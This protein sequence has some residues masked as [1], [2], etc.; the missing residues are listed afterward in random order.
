ME[1]SLGTPATRPLVR[2][3]MCIRLHLKNAATSRIVKIS[4][5]AT[6]TSDFPG[7]DLWLGTE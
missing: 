7:A 6:L 3:Q 2:L 4:P 1:G 5:F